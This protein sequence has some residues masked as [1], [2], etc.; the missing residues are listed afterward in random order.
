MNGADESTSPKAQARHCF[1]S[2]QSFLS[3]SS[4]FCT[5]STICVIAMLARSTCA[6][7]SALQPLTAER[8]A[9]WDVVGSPPPILGPFNKTALKYEDLSCRDP[10]WSV[11]TLLLV[12]PIFQ[13]VSR[14]T[15][16][17][18]F[19]TALIKKTQISQIIFA[20]FNSLS[21]TKTFS[22]AQIATRSQL[23]RPISVALSNLDF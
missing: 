19:C 23:H 8:P 12:R 5:I 1:R 4:F 15:R 9:Q 20:L 13:K 3:F 22:E 2:G 17:T 21:N 14:S 18:H 6:R 16:F 11:S 7:S 10:F